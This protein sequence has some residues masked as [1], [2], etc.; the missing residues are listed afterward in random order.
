[1]A[2]LDSLVIDLQANT[3][4]LKKGLDEA[5]AK[6]K[7]FGEKMNSLAKVVTFDKI[8]HVVKE[9]A[10][11]LVE[12]TLRGAESADRMAKM[13]R[14]AGV[15]VEEFSRLNYAATLG[16]VPTEALGVAFT[17]LNKTLAEAASG[18]KEQVALFKAM[19]IAI[20]DSSGRTRDA[21][22]VLKDVADVF[23]KTS[24]G[25]SKTRLA[26]E[27]F[28]KSGAA[29]IPMLDSGAD[30]IAQL[31]DEADRL[32]ITISSSAAQS[33]EEFNDNLA[34]MKLAME[35]VG[36]K[37]AAEITPALTKLTDEI[38][39]TKDGSS[40]LKDAAQAL[41]AVLKVLASGVVI[42]G[43]AF[44]VVG[45]EIARTASIAV[46]VV[47]GNFAEAL[48][49]AKGYVSDFTG[50]AS[51]AYKKLEAIWS[52]SAV[53]DGAQKTGD[54]ANDAADQ[55]SKRFDALKKAAQEAETAMKALTKVA[56]DYEAKAATF[57]AGPIA[58]LEARLERGDLS[59]QLAK[60][61]DQ[62]E[63]MKNRILEAARALREL[64][65]GRLNIQLEMTREREQGNTDA[66]VRGMVRRMNEVGE[67]PRT[68]LLTRTQGFE[69]FDAALAAYAKQTNAH[70][71]A[72]G[73]AEMLKLDNDLEGAFQAQLAADQA[74]RGADAAK[75]AAES[76]IE[77]K[78]LDFEQARRNIERVFNTFTSI[79]LNFVKELGDLGDV[80]QAGIQGAQV[81]GWYGAIAAVLL[82]I[83]THFERFSE[84]TKLATDQL[85][86]F[87]D[88]IKPALNALTDSIVQIMLASGSFTRIV[89]Q[90]VGPFLREFARGLNH[91]SS[92]LTPILNAVSTSLEPMV[93][94]TSGLQDI[95]DAI[96]PLQ[97]AIKFVAL[98]FNLISLGIIEI[99]NG[100][101]TAWGWVLGAIRDVMRFFLLDTTEIDQTIATHAAKTKELQDR[102]AS[103]W[104]NI[105]DPNANSQDPR[106]VEPIDTSSIDV[107]LENLGDSADAASK[108]LN[109]FTQ[110][111]TNVPTGFKY[112]LRSFEAQTPGIFEGASGQ[113]GDT[114]ITVQG[115]LIHELD[116]VQ[117]MENIKKRDN[118]RKKG[119]P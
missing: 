102:A 30:G 119:I 74:K 14:A 28:G 100:I 11:S 116:L 59:K 77:L 94:L 89:L 3:A 65:R 52:S 12:F 1:M 87:I 43:A 32:G 113:G 57:G 48:N 71:K 50:A 101:F 64:E 45:K 39:K 114:N 41:A 90:F 86:A 112:Q 79:G 7:D 10:T 26:M 9:A 13:A 58:E 106:V 85:G 76:F 25:A 20:T 54:A 66:T 24:D 99:M 55:M 5:N 51:S 68:N 108:S 70:V 107:P 92:I 6:I 84:I 18:S 35:A 96:D 62:A 69:S 33:A 19:G 117:I 61:G 105:L 46:N 29:L 91:V 44:E 21:G 73:D 31:S 27:L 103:I 16:G 56:E 8:A 22:S 81:G 95:I 15:T 36:Q 38:L 75:D 60:I 104:N 49:D 110:Q 88:Q 53:A 97:Y 4:E 42:L 2:K 82:E 83:L 47:N 109:D 80:I 78:N 34:R 72:I 111:L 67:T 118:F 115:S 63:V 93:A 40:T 17:K 98:V 37:A 23:S